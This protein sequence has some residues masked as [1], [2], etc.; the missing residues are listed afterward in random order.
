M[1]KRSLLCWTIS[2]LGIAACSTDTTDDAA[3]AEVGD[4]ASSAPDTAAAPRSGPGPVAP[5]RIIYS[6]LRPGNWDVYYFATPG[7]T[8]ERLTDHSG[9]DYDAIFS[10][11]GRWVVFTSERRGNPDLYALDLQQRGEP[12][13]LIES[14]AMEDQATISPDGQT[15]AFVGTRDGFADIFVLP[16]DPTATRSIDDATNLTH[17]SGGDFRP[18]FSPDGERIAFSS[19]RDTPVYGHP[20]F[21]FTRQREGELYVMNSDGSGQQRLTESPSWDGSPEWSV[22]G[23]TIYFYSA[24]PRE[25]PG[26]P[27]SSIIG[28]EGGFRIWAIDADGSNPR[29]ITAEGMEA[30]APALTAD[31]RIAFQTREGPE[32]WR[33]VSV[34]F[35]GSGLRLESERDNDYWVPDYD[36]ASGAMVSHGVGPVAGVS[37]AVEGVLGAGAL[38]AADYPVEVDLPDRQVTLYPMRH[39][40]GLSPHP[41]RNESAVTVETPEGTRLVRANFDGSNERELF[42]VPGIGITSGSPDRLFDIK[43]SSDGKWLLISQGFMAGDEG[44]KADIWIMRGDGGE[45]RNLTESNDVNDG[46]AA[47]SPDGEKIVFRSSRSGNFELYLM[48][49]DG[50]HVQRLT[51]NDARDNFPAFSPNGDAIVFSSDRDSELDA[52]GFKSF[53]NYVMEIEPDGSPGTVTR[54]TDHPGQDSHPWFSPDAEWIVYTAE[55]YGITDEEPMVQEILF[56]PQMY[57]EIYARR[58]SDNLTIRLTHNKWEEGNPVWFGPALVE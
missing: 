30:L 16:F 45:R 50:G 46:V 2:L 36:A 10:P 49:R 24:R 54:V 43:W 22:D 20:Y 47:F 40:T 9:L 27:T 29:P 56:G 23:E 34:D 38:L 33:I 8:P 19:D 18:A 41:L 51:D 55:R 1:A 58:L 17:S 53:D 5:E 44:T 25:L 57:G 7:E 48:D 14:A 26:P 13:L 11:D 15:M 35:D 32:D 12:R 42:S 52:L 4:A 31:G 37:Q 3:N 6:S 21:P 39:T 28:Q